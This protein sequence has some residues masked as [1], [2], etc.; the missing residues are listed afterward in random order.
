MWGEWTLFYVSRVSRGDGLGWLVDLN[1]HQHSDIFVIWPYKLLRT[2]LLGFHF[3]L[4]TYC[5]H[6][7]AL[8]M[9]HRRHFV[10]L[11]YSY[12]KTACWSKRVTNCLCYCC[13]IFEVLSFSVMWDRGREAVLGSIQ[14]EVGQF[15]N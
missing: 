11:F 13:L 3:M 15:R 7:S 5:S 14:I 10:L 8:N 6:N 12:V 9:N 4:K 1:V 2:T